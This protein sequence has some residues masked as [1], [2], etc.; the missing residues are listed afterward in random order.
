M[1]RQTCY[2]DHTSACYRLEAALDPTPFYVLAGGLTGGFIT[3]LA[4][5]GTGLAAMP[6][7]LLGVSPIVAAQLAAACGAVGQAQNLPAVW[8][9]VRADC[10]GHFVIAGLIG[11]PIG[12]VLLPLIPDRAFKLGVGAFL[13]VFCVF[14][15][16]ARGRTIFTGHNKPLDRGIGFLGGIAAGVAGLSGP[17][18]TAWAML[19]D[20]S[21]DE[22]RAL[23]QCFNF[24]TLVAMLIA[25]TIAGHMSWA[26][27]WA[28][29]I[30]VP[31]T[32][33]GAWLGYA[34]Y[35]RLSG[36]SF[37]NILLAALAVSGC[38][39]VVANL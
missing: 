8:P 12:V 17:I 14:S 38:A 10:V 27:V 9:D 36:K 26:F 24:V 11:V 4:G 19:H 32:L 6:I 21:R 5:F 22:K 16:A 29:L 35:R 25:G 31:G 20:W 1:P 30:A 7:W 2:S 18:P 33:V 34:T 13:L 39:L 37:E 3:G 23:F 28:F 15:V